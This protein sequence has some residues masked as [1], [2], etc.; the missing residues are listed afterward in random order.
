MIEDS[1][2]QTVNLGGFNEMDDVPLVSRQNSVVVDNATVVAPVG[3][4]G[5]YKVTTQIAHNPDE[6]VTVVDTVQNM[7]SQVVDN[8]VTSTS[9]EYTEATSVAQADTVVKEQSPVE[10]ESKLVEGDIEVPTGIIKSML[11]MARKVGVANSLQP[12]SFILNL[13]FN[14]DGVTMRATNGKEDFEYVNTSYIFNKT[15]E[16]VL[17]IKTFG[18]FINSVSCT[19]LGFDYD[20]NQ[21]ILTVRTDNG[22]YKFPQRVDQT[23]NMPFRI[24]L[25]YNDAYENMRPIDY[26]AFLDILNLNKSV[27]TMAS[28]LNMSSIQGTYFGNIVASSDGTIMLLHDNNIGFSDKEFLM[29]TDFCNLLNSVRFNPTKCRVGFIEQEGVLRGIV[30]SDGNVKLCGPIFTPQD[31]PVQ[32]CKDF[33]NSN[34]FSKSVIIKT[35][36]IS[37]LIKSA[38]PFIGLDEANDKVS[39]SISGEMLNITTLNGAVNVHIA[40]TNT[41][42]LNTPEP[43]ILPASRLNVI[44]DNIQ[45]DAFNLTVNP[46]NNICVCLTY[47]DYKCIVSLLGK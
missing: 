1:Q 6:V 29:T 11:S 18:E 2:G 42:N 5:D 44:L 40:V 43:L 7:H 41:S 45:S 27:R 23:T 21:K 10:T 37:N 4:V 32:V 15:I 3:E 25:N 14:S 16:A 34:E 22:T 17:D 8:V 19:Y 36:A 20:D 24:E 38:I 30:I 28:K 47:D 12:K 13:T 26:N 31:F 9:V 39:L 35:Q 46:D 33:W